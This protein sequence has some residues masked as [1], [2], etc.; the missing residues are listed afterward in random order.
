MRGMR[1]KWGRNEINEEGMRRKWRNEWNQWKNEWNEM[2][3]NEMKWNEMKWNG[4]EWMNEWMNEEVN[5][6]EMRMSNE[7]RESKMRGN[8]R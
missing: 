6:K 7:E 1:K 2:K 4:M 5:E 3:W 8:E